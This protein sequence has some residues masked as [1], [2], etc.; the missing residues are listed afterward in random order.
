MDGERSGY[1]LPGEGARAAAL[2]PSG[3]SAERRV[4]RIDGA[5]ARSQTVLAQHIDLVWLTPQMDRLFQ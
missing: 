5:T 3:E 1:M 2:A 4:V